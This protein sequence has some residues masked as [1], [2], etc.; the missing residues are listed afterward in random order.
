MSP[1]I[2]EYLHSAQ[3]CKKASEVIDIIEHE[4]A[5]DQIEVMLIFRKWLTQIRN[6]LE[7]LN[8]S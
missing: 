6:V 5:G 4:M 8:V 2:S 7:T 1:M 3:S